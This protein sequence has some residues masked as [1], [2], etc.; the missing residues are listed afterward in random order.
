MPSRNLITA[1]PQVMPAPNPQRTAVE[2]S[3]I[4]PFSTPSQRAIG[5]DAADVLP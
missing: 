2:P 4:F 5:I 1:P 3:F